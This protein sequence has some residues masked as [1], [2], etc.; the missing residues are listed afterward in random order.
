VRCGTR[1][2]RAPGYANHLK[3]QDLKTALEDG[4]VTANLVAVLAQTRRG[5]EIA[6]EADVHLFNYEPRL[7]R[8]N[9]HYPPTTLL[10]VENTHN[11]V[12]L[13]HAASRDGR[14]A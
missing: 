11:R 12:G 4:L 10:A 3:R 8:A 6:G 7:R 1:T 5:D 13:G 9:D 14:P 2:G